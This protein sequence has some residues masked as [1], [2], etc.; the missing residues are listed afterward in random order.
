MGGCVGRLLCPISDSPASPPI[1]ATAAATCPRSGAA[2][3]AQEQPFSLCAS[4]RLPCLELLCRPQL[5]DAYG[6]LPNAC[7][8]QGSEKKNHQEAL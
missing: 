4:H 6:T 5:W 2:H 7:I 1:P 3:L 8:S